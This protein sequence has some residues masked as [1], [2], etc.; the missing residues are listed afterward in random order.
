MFTVTMYTRGRLRKIHKEKYYLRKPKK[1]VL[2]N[3]IKKHLSQPP[4]KSS[5]Q[6]ESGAE[7][8]TNIDFMAYARNISLKTIQLKSLA[9]FAEHLSE[10][11][12]SFSCHSQRVDIIFDVYVDDS[13]TTFKGT[14]EIPES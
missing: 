6:K 5:R 9:G 13:I 10:I 8:V 3:K 7:E 11:F 1:H 14:E 12:L 4:A 2:V